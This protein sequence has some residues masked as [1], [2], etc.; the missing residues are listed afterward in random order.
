MSCKQMTMVTPIHL[1]LFGSRK[2]EAVEEVV[3]R[4]HCPL[5]LC[6]PQTHLHKL[7]TALAFCVCTVSLSYNQTLSVWQVRLDGWINLD[8]DKATASKIVGLRPCMEDL[9][10]R[11]SADPESVSE[12]SNSDE[13]VGLVY[14]MCSQGIT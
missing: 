3:S 11:G 13:Q 10:V 1:M 9:I 6:G 12:P 4:L 8:L 14:V 2:V 7:C 5:G